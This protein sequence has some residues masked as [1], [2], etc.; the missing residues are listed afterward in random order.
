MIDDQKVRL[1][2]F[3]K[4]QCEKYTRATNTSQNLHLQR[5][6]NIKKSSNV[7]WRSADNECFEDKIK[8]DLEIVCFI[9]YII[10]IRD[11]EYCDNLNGLKT[12]FLF[13]YKRFNE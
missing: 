11:C 1:Q 9:F 7:S 2:I 12:P 8:L 13:L 10:M 6:F 4:I 5:T 3:D